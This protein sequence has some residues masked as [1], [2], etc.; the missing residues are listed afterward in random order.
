MTNGPNRVIGDISLR[1]GWIVTGW[2]VVPPP[3]TSMPVAVHIDRRPVGY[4]VATTSLGEATQDGLHRLEYDYVPRSLWVHGNV[5]LLECFDP[6]G[7]LIGRLSTTLQ[8]AK[9]YN[10]PSEF[11]AWA[12]YHRI[13]HGPFT[14]NDEICL[15]YFDWYATHC[16][17]EAATKPRL[18]VSGVMPCWNSA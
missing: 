11:L 3:L 12:Y 13:L 9:P 6:E 4:A 14:Q 15:S 7:T 18:P 1:D 8:Q 5:H 17:G 10:S 16:A 2:V